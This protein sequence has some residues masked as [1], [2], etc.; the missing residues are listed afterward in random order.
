[1]KKGF[2]DSSIQLL[3]GQRD[4]SMTHATSIIGWKIKKPDLF[5]AMFTY[6]NAEKGLI[7]I[8]LSPDSNKL[9]VNRGKA[10]NEGRIFRTIKRLP[11]N[12]AITSLERF[13][14]ESFLPIYSRKKA[15]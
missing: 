8:G 7:A 11:Q 9:Y 5:Y 13:C 14:D 4:I 6:E 10:F 15:E 2:S 3:L 1:M 12:T